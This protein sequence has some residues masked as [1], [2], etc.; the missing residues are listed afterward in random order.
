[1]RLE[2][3]EWLDKALSQLPDTQRLTV[4]LHDAMGLTVAEIA[5]S[6]KVPVP[7]AK[8]RLRRGRMELV[9]LLDDLGYEGR[10]M[11]T[12]SSAQKTEGNNEQ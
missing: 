4:L 2:R 10:T 8:A 12:A 6:T 9:S 5:Q 1:M 11:T 3:L 7:T